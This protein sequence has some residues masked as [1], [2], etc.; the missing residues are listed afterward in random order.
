MGE[1]GARDGSDN[2]CKITT[3]KAN[4]KG[5]VVRGIGQAATIPANFLCSPQA[6]SPGGAGLCFHRKAAY[7]T[8]LPPNCPLDTQA[9]NPGVIY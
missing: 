3:V 5:E 2:P 9:P 6:W 1:S 4:F 8:E 7:L